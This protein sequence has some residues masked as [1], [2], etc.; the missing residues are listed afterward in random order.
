MALKP[1]YRGGRPRTFTEEQ[2]AAIIE[3]AQ[4]PPNTLDLPFT[5]WSLSKLKEEAERRG[6]V[7]SISIETVVS[8]W[9][10]PTSPTNT[11]RYGKPRMILILR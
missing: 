9:R 11:P 6:I 10:K 8:F 4:I 1:R 3:L 5:H 2:R 7:T